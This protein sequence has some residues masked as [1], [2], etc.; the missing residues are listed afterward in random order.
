MG[1]ANISSGA[2]MVDVDWVV[3]SADSKVVLAML[4]MEV[5]AALG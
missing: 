3:G 4:E 1:G 5:M 2:N